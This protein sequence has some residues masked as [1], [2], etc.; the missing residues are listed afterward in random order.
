MTTAPNGLRADFDGTTIRVEFDTEDGENRLSPDMMKWTTELLLTPPEG[1]RVLVLSAVGSAFCLGPKRAA[2]A[3]QTVHD[4][5]L[6]IATFNQAMRETELVT[7]A[8]VDGTAAGFGVGVACLPDIT[9][10]GD[11]ASFVLPEVMHDLTPALVLSW[12]VD[13]TGPKTSRFLALSGLSIG[14]DRAHAVGLVDMVV[15]SAALTEETEQLVEHL[16]TM[17]PATVSEIKRFIR[18]RRGLSSPDAEVLAIERMSA[19]D[20]RR[21]QPD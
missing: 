8:Q 4:L 15:S 14:V 1:A 5:G 17:A 12:L 11:D 13:V 9:I 18:D 2:D 19:W 10:G 7:I 16:M 6:S 20:E 21:N 3:G